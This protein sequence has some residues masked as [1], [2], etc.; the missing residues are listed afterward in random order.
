[1][2][3]QR[4]YQIAL[5]QLHGIG[6]R[7]ASH[8]L[9]KTSDLERIFKDT[10][11]SLHKLTGIREALLC[12]M[13]RDEA[14]ER[15]KQEL[16]FIDKMGINVHFYLDSNYPRRLK[17][18]PDLP[19]VL[20]SLG[21]VDLHAKRTV[22]VVGTRHST[23]YGDHLCAEFI[24]GL[25]GANVQ[26]ISGLAYGID[27]CAHQ[28]CLQEGIP[29]VAVFGHGL[30]R[31]Y[32]QA[33]RTIARKMLENGGWISEFMSKTTPEREHFPM[34][35]RIVA[36]MSDAVT[37]IESK[38]NGGSLITAAL[39]NDYQKDVFAFPGNIGQVTSEGCNT[40]IRENGAHLVTGTFDFLQQMGWS[41]ENKNTNESQ[42]VQ[43]IDPELVKVLNIIEEFPK[44]HI[45]LLAIRAEIPIQQ[46]NRILVE[47]ELLQLINVF[48]GNSYLRV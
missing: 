28:T 3:D 35:N 27:Y 22:A 41:I 47:L 12:Q 5:S 32:P 4:I 25:S 23:A 40:L 14:L 45:D 39:A 21:N 6:P 38:L 2:T 17:Q 48:P 18:C 33:H 15:A 11:H 37:V 13:R 34:R 1:M 42:R 26:V 8:L 20:Y 44:I 19:I 36:G 16:V 9:A 31:I 7:R 46:M 30:D 43:D 10:I 24:Q 29:T